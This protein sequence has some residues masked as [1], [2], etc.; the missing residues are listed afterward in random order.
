MTSDGGEVLKVGTD[1]VQAADW[2]LFRAT[3]FKFIIL[4]CKKFLLGFGLTLI[5]VIQKKYF[6]LRLSLNY[7]ERDEMS[8]LCSSFFFAINAF[9][10]IIFV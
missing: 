1:V 10:N 2:D 6:Q 8:S 9:R 4:A 7:S 5:E 3:I